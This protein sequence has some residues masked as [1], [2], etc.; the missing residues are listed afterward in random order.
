MLS[1][2]NKNAPKPRTAGQ[3]VSPSRFGL[4]QARG[5]G[6]AMESTRRPAAQRSRLGANGAQMWRY[7]APA[8][9]AGTVWHFSPAGG[10][11]AQSL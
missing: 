3:G 8:E 6:W 1:A 7:E 5:G 2:A 10:Q 9:F 11:V 4:W